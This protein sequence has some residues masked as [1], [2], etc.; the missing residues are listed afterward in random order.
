MTDMTAILIT[1]NHLTKKV[2]LHGGNIKSAAAE[3]SDLPFPLKSNAMGPATKPT[4][5]QNYT[6][7]MGQ[8]DRC[9][10]MTNS[11]SLQCWT[12]K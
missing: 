1:V 4:I 12:Q 11:Y 6:T 9:D 8:V 7:E 3:Q 10:R 2:Q 5:L